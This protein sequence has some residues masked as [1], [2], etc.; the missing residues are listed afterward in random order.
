MAE[1]EAAVVPE[2]EPWPPLP[3]TED[4]PV[5][6]PLPPGEPPKSSKAPRE[7]ENLLEGDYAQTL[8]FRNDGKVVPTGGE[9]ND[10]V[11][12][13]CEY[14]FNYQQWI[15]GQNAGSKKKTGKV[16]G[17]GGFKRKR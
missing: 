3:P 10:H 7:P 1:A 12:R 17:D 8:T 13:Q 4:T 9:M 11:L 16:T 15:D 6:P 2:V 14:Y 5:W